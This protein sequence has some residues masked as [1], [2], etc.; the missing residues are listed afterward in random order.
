LRKHRRE[1]DMTTL[2][3]PTSLPAY[4][5]RPVWRGWVRGF[6]LRRPGGARTDGVEFLV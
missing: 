1:E 2:L 4:G 5:F 6:S 3:Y